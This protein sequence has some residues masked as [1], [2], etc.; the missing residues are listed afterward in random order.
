[1]QCCSS[2]A[3]AAMLLLRRR[4]AERWE[5]GH[6]K[7]QSTSGGSRD[8]SCLTAG[9]QR[10]LPSRRRR[11]NRDWTVEEPGE[12]GGQRG[13]LQLSYLN[14]GC[15]IRKDISE[16]LLLRLPVCKYGWKKQ[17]HVTLKSGRLRHREWTTSYTLLQ[18]NTRWF[19]SSSIH[20]DEFV[21][22]H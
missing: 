17:S 10:C 3:T 4:P 13:H 20:D 2:W 15:K 14:E 8:L 19:H 9:L 1:M 7:E 22:T 11:D 12:T 6:R 18:K 21:Q 5:G 16:L